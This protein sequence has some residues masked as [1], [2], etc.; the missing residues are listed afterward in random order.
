MSV[1]WGVISF[2]QQVRGGLF[3]LVD[4][5]CLAVKAGA[6]WSMTRSPL[7]GDHSSGPRER[8]RADQPGGAPA[9]DPQRPGL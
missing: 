7:L 1:I 9:R 4:V 6:V 3:I 2:G 8:G 5:I